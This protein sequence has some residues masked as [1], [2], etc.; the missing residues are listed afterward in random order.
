MLVATRCYLRGRSHTEASIHVHC[1][2]V[3]RVISLA[4]SSNHAYVA[5]GPNVMTGSRSVGTSH[6]PVSHPMVSG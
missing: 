3:L 4:K 6:L 2:Q 1:H 5:A